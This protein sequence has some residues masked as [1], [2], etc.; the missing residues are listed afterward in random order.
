MAAVTK[1]QTW[2]DYAR[3]IAIILVLYRHVFEGLKSAGL[4]V[5][6]YIELEHANVLFFSFRM[7][8]FFIVSGIFFASSLQKRGLGTFTKVKAQT[9]LYPYFI[10]GFIQLTIQIILSGY[11]NANRS[12][13]D[14]LLLLYL[15]RGV[16]QFWYLYALFNVSV[17]YAIMTAVAKF[18]YRWNLLLGIAL[19]YLSAYLG[20]HKIN[21]WF[22]ADIMH[23]YVFYAIGDAIGRFI[24]DK[25]NLRLLQSWKM[26]GILLLPFMATQWYFL[27]ENLAHQTQYYDYVEYHQPSLFLLIA[28]TGCAFVM[29]VAFLLQRYNAMPWLHRLGKHSL[30]I[31]VAHVIA[32][33]GIRIVLL[34]FFSITSVPVHLIAGIVGGLLLPIVLYK[35]SLRFKF[36]WLFT[37]EKQ[38]AL[39]PEIKK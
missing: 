23:Y 35:L 24:R 8:L 6:E 25:E 38:P 26:W 17:L 34:K 29:S 9:I 39:Q 22:L 30:Y 15:P 16:E 2:I 5:Q 32:L 37:L 3:G 7:P 4:A 1:R 36:A 12:A 10:W 33:A 19:Y 20:Q 21:A 11:V 13:E 28:L 27:K 14:Y 31:Y 18:D